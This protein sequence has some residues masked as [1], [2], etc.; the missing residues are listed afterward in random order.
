MALSLV[1]Q[2]TGCIFYA[3]LKGG[4]GNCENLKTTH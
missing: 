4:S 1:V 3:L 2:P